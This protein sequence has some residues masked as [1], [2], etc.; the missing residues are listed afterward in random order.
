[1]AGRRYDD[2]YEDSLWGR[3]RQTAEITWIRMRDVKK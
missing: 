2:L 1:M 3:L